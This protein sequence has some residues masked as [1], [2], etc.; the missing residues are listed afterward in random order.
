M[1]TSSG[2]GKKKKKRKV[3]KMNLSL[4]VLS[5]L[6]KYPKIGQFIDY[7]DHFGKYQSDHA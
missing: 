6:K 7:F 1:S 4:S 2:G 3:Y 5:H